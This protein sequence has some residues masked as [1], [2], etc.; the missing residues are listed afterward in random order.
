MMMKNKKYLIIN[1]DDFGMSSE[2]NQ[3]ICYLMTQGIVSSTSL[4]ANGNAYEDAIHDIRRLDLKNIGVHLTL[5]CD[6]FENDDKITYS[7]VTH[8]NSLEDK[9]GILYC[10]YSDFAVN[11]TD[12]DI[13][14]EIYSQ[15]MKIKNAGIEFTHIDNHMYS[16]IH[17]LGLRGYKCFYK[18]IHRLKTSRKI[19]LRHAIRKY[20]IDGVRSVYP[21]RKI[22]PYAWAMN[23]FFHLRCPD[24]VYTL[25]YASPQSESIEQKC[26]LL[27][28]FF[29]N[30]KNG[31][32][33]LHVHPAVF[34]E[35]LRKR[36][37]TWKDRI[38]EYE[39][40][41][42]F[43]KELLMDKYGITLISYADLVKLPISIF[44][45]L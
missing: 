23:L 39:A 14:N 35:E 25:P 45:P 24:F 27:N 37:P 36:N 8:A 10:S 4:M 18:A 34:S 13:I 28:S 11:A 31:V 17:N 9:D 16:V 6:G 41:N 29:S 33:E 19:G 1:A 21:G 7:S 2:F 32:S 12:E 43:S 40:L 3:A 30:I 26:D 5:T 38:D 22:Q 20:D 42:C 15:I 44:S